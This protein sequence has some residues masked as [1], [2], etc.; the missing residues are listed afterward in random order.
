MCLHFL[1]PLTCTE[2]GCNFWYSA[3]PKPQ[4]GEKKQTWH[5]TQV[6]GAWRDQQSAGQVIHAGMEEWHWQPQRH[7]KLITKNVFACAACE[8]DPIISQVL[9]P[10]AWWFSGTLK[11]ESMKLL[12]WKP[13]PTMEVFFPNTLTLIL[14]WSWNR[15]LAGNAFYYWKLLLIHECDLIWDTEERLNVDQSNLLL[16]LF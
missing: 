6:K 14:I 8:L 16:L 1:P 4:I 10:W 11:I 13:R 9:V 12:K 15:F 5:C 7:D 3:I 2:R